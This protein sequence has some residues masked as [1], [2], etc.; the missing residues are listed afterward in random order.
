MELPALELAGLW[1]R[2]GLN[3]EMEAFGRALVN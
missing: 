3:I 2:F 1:V